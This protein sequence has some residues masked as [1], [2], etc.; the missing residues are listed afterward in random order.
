MTGGVFPEGVTLEELSFGGGRGSATQ[1]PKGQT[2]R[3][4]S[5]GSSPALPASGDHKGG[6]QGPPIVGGRPWDNTVIFFVEYPSFFPS[7][8]Q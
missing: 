4:R 8:L 1:R 3:C 6:D 7:I 5:G 2:R